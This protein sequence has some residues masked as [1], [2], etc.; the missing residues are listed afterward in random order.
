MDTLV[1][2]YKNA[3][4]AG[5]YVQTRL[6]AAQEPPQDGLS[7]AEAVSQHRELDCVLPCGVDAS[8]AKVVACRLQVHVCDSG[9]E[10]CTLAARHIAPELLLRTDRGALS[11]FHESTCF[12][13]PTDPSALASAVL[14][15]GTRERSNVM[16]AAMVMAFVPIGATR[17]VALSDVL[18]VLS[19]PPHGHRHA[20]ARVLPKHAAPAGALQ[21]DA[22]ARCAPSKW[23]TCVGAATHV[24]VPTPPS[25]RGL[26]AWTVHA[27]GSYRHSPAP[28]DIAEPPSLKKPRI[29]SLVAEVHACPD[30]RDGQLLDMAAAIAELRAQLAAAQQQRDGFARA[31]RLLGAQL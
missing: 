21:L 11:A 26:A 15:V 28:A 8:C 12:L 16:R 6:R 31:L 1:I 24:L 27:L 19:K 10:P 4:R 14:H 5:S 30:A 9:G 17:A 23:L 2:L 13:M 29:A 7:V 18:L 20:F 22:S 25:D 3:S